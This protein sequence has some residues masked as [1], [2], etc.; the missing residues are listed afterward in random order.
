MPYREDK[1]IEF[2]VPFLKEDTVL[3]VPDDMGMF[4]ARWMENCRYAIVSLFRSAGKKLIFLPDLLRTLDSEL[5]RYMFPGQDSHVVEEAVYRRLVEVICTGGCPGFLYKQGGAVY[6]HAVA[7]ATDDQALRDIRDFTSFLTDIE[8]VLPCEECGYILFR[9]GSSDEANY[10]LERSSRKEAQ[11]LQKEHKAKRPS[12]IDMLFSAE[13][14]AEREQV[15]LDPRA[16]E[17]LKAW[18]TIERDFGITVEGLELLLGYQVKLSRLNITTANKLFLTDFDNQEVKM[19]DLTKALYFF[20]LLHPEGLRLK[21]LHEH[22]DEIV[23]IYSG[24]TGRD[25]TKKIRKSVQNLLDPFGNNLNVSMSRIK[26]A[27]KD[28]VSERVA[29][30][31]YVSGSYGETRNVGLD[32]DLVIWE[33]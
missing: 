31:Y 6:Y 23:H 16:Q 25:D 7:A 10:E 27:F 28:V 30:F 13:S 24:I 19:D 32:R 26:K 3:Y 15:V 12:F 21:E 11:R 17:I 8:V 9:K 1:R 29:R 14:E 18:N 33:H 20:Y 2:P 22:E 5:L 4:S